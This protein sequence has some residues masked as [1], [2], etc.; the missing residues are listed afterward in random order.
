MTLKDRI[1]EAAGM[2]LSYL[3]DRCDEFLIGY[4]ELGGRTRTVA[5]YGY[6]AAKAALTSR[7]EDPARM[8]V[9]LQTVLV[10]AESSDVLMLTR[11]SRKELWRRI[12]EKAYNRWELMDN[13]VVGIGTLRNDVPRIVYN[14]ALCVDVLLGSTAV[15]DT[16]RALTDAVTYVEDKVIGVDL[17]DNS[18]WFLTQVK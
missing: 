12:F 13:A 11:Y 10:E 5:C 18:A 4:A 8:Y 1:N 16:A 15:Q 2:D 14:K 3:S 17:G 9:E 7:Y 6:Q